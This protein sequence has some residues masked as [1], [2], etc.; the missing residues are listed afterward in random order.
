MLR[1]KCNAYLVAVVELAEKKIGAHMTYFKC[2]AY[3]STAPP[4][5][6]GIFRAN[7]GTQLHISTLLSTEDVRRISQVY[8][9]KVSMITV[10]I[11]HAYIRSFEEFLRNL[12]EN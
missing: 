6:T 5:L 2:F 10:G 9:V 3:L 12:C 11:L 8:T 7:T 4:P 1:F